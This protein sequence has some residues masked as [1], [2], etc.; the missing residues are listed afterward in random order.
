[1]GFDTHSTQL[2]NQGSLL[3]EL[4]AAVAA[5]VSATDEPGMPGSDKVTTFT[6]SDFNRTFRIGAA[7]SGTD[8]AWGGHQMVIGSAVRGGDFYGQ[9]PILALDGPD[10]TDTGVA[11]RG[12]WIPT[13]SV[14][15]YGATLASWF[16]VP[17]VR[18]DTIFPNLGQFATRNLGFMY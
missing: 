15:Q 3:T 16:G 10:D 18:L 13:T 6:L 11:A 1:G 12:R 7:A 8:H 9:Y 17:D 14:D 4:A 2:I 5:F